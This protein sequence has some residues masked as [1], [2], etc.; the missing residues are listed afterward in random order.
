MITSLKEKVDSVLHRLSLQ[1]FLSTVKLASTIC[2]TW[3]LNMIHQYCCFGYLKDTLNP[4]LRFAMLLCN[5]MEQTVPLTQQKTVSI[6]HGLF[7]YYDYIIRDLHISSVNMLIMIKTIII[8]TIHMKIRPLAFAKPTS[9]LSSLSLFPCQ[10]QYVLA[11]RQKVTIQ[12][13]SR[14]WQERTQ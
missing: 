8:M 7:L 11:Y 14:F 1:C 9:M 5:Y 3:Q 4:D 10:H 13:K 6:C 2:L 12:Y